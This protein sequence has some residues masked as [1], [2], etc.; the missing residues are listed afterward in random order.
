MP[1]NRSN[2]ASVWRKKARTNIPLS[3]KQLETLKELSTR[4]LRFVDDANDAILD[5]EVTTAMDGL[6]LSAARNARESIQNATEAFAAWLPIP[7]PIK[8][9]KA[10]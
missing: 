10:R 9:R 1:S 3:P 6:D 8:R 2:D 5:F 4:W 7:E